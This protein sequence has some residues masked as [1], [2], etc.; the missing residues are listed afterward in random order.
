M[1]SI[2]HICMLVNAFNNTCLWR[3]S[4]N[5]DGQQYFQY[6]QNEQLKCTSHYKSLTYANLINM[7]LSH[8]L[9]W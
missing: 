6:Q 9:I 7:F 5:S 2:S 3:E 1:V 8:L 4:L